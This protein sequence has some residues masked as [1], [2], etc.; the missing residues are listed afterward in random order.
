MRVARISRLFT[1]FEEEKEGK[2][3]P[4]NE[5]I[6]FIGLGV[7][8][9]PMCGHIARKGDNRVVGYDNVSAA[10]EATAS[11][12]VEAGASLAD[13]AAAADI[14]FLSLPGEPQIRDVCQGEGGLIGLA[15]LRKPTNKDLLFMIDIS[16]SMDE[17]A[18][19]ED[20]MEAAGGGCSVVLLPA[21]SSISTP[22]RMSGEKK[23]IQRK[24]LILQ[25]FLFNFF[26][27]NQ[28]FQIFNILIKL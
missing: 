27:F 25:V 24:S 28:I 14:I 5:V 16:Y 13:V 11:D 10:L 12:G 1:K 4:S 23:E 17:V 18:G 6:G 7:M 20:G 22:K 8:G 19:Y 26:L 3:M 2:E 21:L 9:G 15:S